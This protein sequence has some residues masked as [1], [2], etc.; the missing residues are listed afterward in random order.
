MKVDTHT[1]LL[2][3]AQQCLSPNHDER[4]EVPMDLIV[5]H[6][7]SLPPGEFGGTFIEDFFC[8][9][10]D[11]NAHDYFA[12]IA[13][14][15]VSSHLL[16]KRDGRVVQFVPFH[17][18]AWHAGASCFEGREQCND[19]SIGIELEGTDELPYEEVQYEMLSEIIVALQQT[20]PTL[21]QTR[22]VGHSHIAPSRKTDPGP[23]FNWAHLH[24]L[25]D[26][27]ANA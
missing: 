23:A 26:S 25:I 5:I 3:G 15:K 7:I 6:N 24:G 8:N 17:K 13:G 10:L 4:P 1:G 27:L 16:I 22:L 14:L 11:A 21:A 20:Y 12:E 19:F 9:R 18:R 2:D